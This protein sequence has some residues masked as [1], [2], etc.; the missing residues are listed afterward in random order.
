MISH[1]AF[2]YFL[3]SKLVKDTFCWSSV[4][5]GGRFLDPGGPNKVQ[6]MPHAPEICGEDLAGSIPTGLPGVRLAHRTCDGRV[7]C[8]V[9]AHTL[10]ART[11]IGKT[12]HGQLSF[13]TQ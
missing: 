1:R 3:V 4:F 8:K 2:A 5:A 7:C 13:F 12:A 11:G 9:E 10:G 6:S